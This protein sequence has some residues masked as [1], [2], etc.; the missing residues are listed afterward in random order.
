LSRPFRGLQVWLPL[1]LHGVAAFRDALDTSL[2]LADHAYRRLSG[3]E[4]IETPW[5]PDLSIVS[6]RFADD[7]VGRA[8]LEA[9]NS[10]RR[11]HLSPT[12]VADRFILRFAVLNRR[13]TADHIDHAIDIIEKDPDRVDGPS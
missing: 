3:I 11:V 2:D 4:G 6:F 8:A 12:T 13:T 9:V 5:R 10:D 1:H 7:E